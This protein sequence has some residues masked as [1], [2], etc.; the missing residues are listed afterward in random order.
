M[1]GS[2]KKLGELES[3]IMNLTQE[4][5]SLRER[6]AEA[7]RQCEASK[8]HCSDTEQRN[9]EM[10]QLFSSLR[11][12]RESLVES[13]QT[14]AT[15]ATNLLKER[16][17]SIEAGAMASSSRDAVHSIS[18]DLNQL[19][20]N[21]RNAMEKV[22]SLRTSAEQIGGIINLIKEI[23]DQTNLLALNAAIEA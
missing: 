22:T 6:L 5:Q 23:A 12:Y 17:Q 2:K 18:R 3:K 4:N 19:A 10:Q 8:Q 7:E 16:E 15:L 20:N 9:R 11:S 13:Q 21:S 1:F 14:L